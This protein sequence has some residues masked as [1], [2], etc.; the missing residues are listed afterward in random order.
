[1]ATSIRIEFESAHD[2]VM[3]RGNCRNPIVHEDD[4][5]EMFV[6]TLAQACE[7][8][9]WRVHPWALM[10]NHCHLFI[11]SPEANLVSGMAWL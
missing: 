8:T 4:H 3:A 6:K 10:N 1:M 5:R 2:H 7:R 9:G 11:E